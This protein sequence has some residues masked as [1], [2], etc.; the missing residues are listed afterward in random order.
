MNSKA[1]AALSTVNS[2]LTQDNILFDSQV[3]V[4]S[5]GV[6]RVCF[7]YVRKVYGETV[8]FLVR[9]ISFE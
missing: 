3:L 8:I 9:E 6:L 4:L 2:N 1:I 7:M 5:I